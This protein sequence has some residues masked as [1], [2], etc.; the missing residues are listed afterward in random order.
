[1]K[2]I[3]IV[4]V[5]LL[6]AGGAVVA[7]GLKLRGT[8]AP[9]TPDAVVR[10]EP[11]ASGDLV[12]IISAP[13]E[14][15][16][17]VKVSISSKVAAPIIYLPFKEGDAVTMG[18][19]KTGVPASVMVRLDDRDL[20][21]ALRSAQ[22]RYDAQKA[23]IEVSRQHIA[24][25]R[26]QIESS[27]ANLLDARRDLDR[28]V[29]LLKTSDVSQSVVDTAETKFD[30]MKAQIDAAAFSLKADE[31]NLIVEQHQLA[32]A[33]ADV[34]K[35]KDD[36]S[37]T[38]IVSPINGIV[39][40]RKAE[41]GE[42]VVPGIQG[43]PGTTIMEVADLSQML[44]VARIDESSVTQVAPKQRATVRMQAFSNRLFEGEVEWVA[45]SRADPSA[46]SAA[47]AGADNSRYFECKIR[48]D[49]KGTVVPSGLSA[50]ADIEVHRHY[51]IRV[52]SQAVLGRPTE[53]LPPR[54]RSAPEVDASKA[55]ASVVYRLVDGKAAATPVIVGASDETHTLIKQ[56]LKEGDSVIVGPYKVLETLAD[57]QVVKA[58]AGATK[59]AA[60]PATR[61]ATAPASRPA[62]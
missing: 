44:M 51:G 17:R 25:S 48:L 61:P 56:G 58:E 33:E 60:P 52:P 41:V 35:A 24:S 31:A 19:P 20:Q 6:L 8:L 10:V 13:G 37:Y 55:V 21:S 4:V 50:D 7:V 27:R 11:A 5:S 53:S 30:S 16:P 36:L 26:S 28:Q 15:Q 42:M 29:G 39:T 43:S 22:A 45:N 32:A 3:A 46:G 9:T 40:R 23:Q 57:G 54:V 47:S 34:G 62:A 2:V 49:T 1:M 38:V 14:V 18:D 12:E 59:A